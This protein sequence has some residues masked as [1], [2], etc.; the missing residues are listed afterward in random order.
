MYDCKTIYLR[1]KYPEFQSYR[2]KQIKQPTNKSIIHHDH[3]Q[4]LRHREVNPSKCA[5]IVIDIQSRFRSTS[6]TILQTVNRTISLCRSVNIPVIFIRHVD[7]PNYTLLGELWGNDIRFMEVPNNDFLPDLSIK[8]D[9]MVLEKYT[10]SCF[11]G[12]ALEAKLKEMEV[13]EVIITG[14]QT[15]MCC[16]TTGREAFVKGFRVFFSTDATATFTDQLQDATL[17]NMAFAFAYLV[18]C[19]MLEM[20]FKTKA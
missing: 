18:D 13:E 2:P 5:L 16:E 7:D 10:Y 11:Q 6:A 8:N 17:T 1:Y 14:V 3:R 4:R 20:S 12:T 9:D 19:D 15:N